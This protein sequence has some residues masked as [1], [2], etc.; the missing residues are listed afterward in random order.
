MAF[1]CK[2][3]RALTG[4][5]SAVL[6]IQSPNLVCSAAAVDIKV[7]TSKPSYVLGEPVIL[8]VSVTNT[9]DV[10][11]KAYEVISQYHPLCP[12]INIYIAPAGPYLIEGDDVLKQF[13]P[14]PCDNADREYEVHSLNPGQSWMYQLRVLYAG[15]KNAR[16]AFPEPGEYRLTVKY[17]LLL[18]DERAVVPLDSAS[19]YVDSNIVAVQIK[20]PSGADASVWQRL[21]SPEVLYFL[22]WGSVG[23]EE[24]VW[25]LVELLKEEPSSGYHS[26]IR[27]ALKSYYRRSQ[28]NLTEHEAE[29]LRS[30]T[31]ITPPADYPFPDD[32]RLDEVITYHFP[33][34]TPLEDVFRELSDRSGVDLRLHPDLQIRQLRGRRVTKPLREFMREA[35]DYKAEWVRDDRSYTLRPL[36]APDDGNKT[37]RQAN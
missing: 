31:A 21:R 33:E 35:A 20:E 12:E 36:S 29:L 14:T 4:L 23:N 28:S 19:H 10:P 24:V 37:S 17:P 25:S 6:L 22:Q 8:R 2:C 18:V 13:V 34:L 26:E 27:W 3:L 11:L 16:L 7:S 32:K 1:S 15:G 30:V 9:D 5:C